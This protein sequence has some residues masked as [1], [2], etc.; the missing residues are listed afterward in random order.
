MTAADTAQQ[1]VAG[2]LL[3]DKLAAYTGV[4]SV[5]SSMQAGKPELHL[6]L[7]SMAAYY[8]LTMHIWVNK[9]DML[10]WAW[11]RFYQ[12][13]DEIR[14]MLRLP[15]ADRRLLDRLHSMPI[16]LDNGKFVPF[17]VVAEAEYAAGL[18]QVTRQNR[19]HIQLVSA[20][21]HNDETNIETVLSD[22]HTSV[23]PQLEAQFP[24]LEIKSD[25][26]RQKQ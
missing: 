12:D 13:R 16:K 7:K 24:G 9:C 8:G 21:I 17:S 26:A 4:H 3:K 18:A 10:F 23:I 25:Q 15:S 2:E 14:V 20:E 6:K 19:E 5:S 11:K 22:L 1:S